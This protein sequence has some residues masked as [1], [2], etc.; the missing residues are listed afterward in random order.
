M[1]LAHILDE[2]IFLAMPWLLVIAVSIWMVAL[3][4]HLNRRRKA[5]ATYKAASY[6]LSAICIL[7]F[8]CIIG[9]ITSTIGTIVSQAQQDLHSLIEGNISAVTV[10]GKSLEAPD[11][12]I[13]DLRHMNM[14]WFRYNHTHPIHRISVDLQTPNGPVS[15]K[16]GRDSGNPHIYW[17]FYSGY[18]ATMSND[19]GKITTS[20]LD[21]N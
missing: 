2:T 18:K 1:T 20:A 15:L 8:G 12:F 9:L 5:D 14:S 21:D 3:I 17:V 19:I 13:S 7:G 16:L 10:N 4:V 6:R 11:T